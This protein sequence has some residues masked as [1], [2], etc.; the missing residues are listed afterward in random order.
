M[1]TPSPW[2][3]EDNPIA[4][5]STAVMLARPGATE[6]EEAE[7]VEAVY[8]QRRRRTRTEEGELVLEEQDLV[9]TERRTIWRG[10]QIK[11]EVN[12]EGHD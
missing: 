2:E 12:G 5:T 1:L 4:Q 10:A 6:A 3:Q 9:F 11:A 8:S 7:L